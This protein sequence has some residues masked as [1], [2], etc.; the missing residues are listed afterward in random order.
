[1]S[2]SLSIHFWLTGRGRFQIQIWSSPCWT[3]CG[4]ASAWLWLWRCEIWR[5]RNAGWMKSRGHHQVVVVG[6]DDWW[7]LGKWFL[8]EL[9]QA[10]NLVLPPAIYKS[11]GII[12]SI[13][14]GYHCWWHVGGIP[15]KAQKL[16]QHDC[17]LGKNYLFQPTVQASSDHPTDHQ[18]I[19]PSPST[20]MRAW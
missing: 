16:S 17:F 13:V 12:N 8:W 4:V 10:I 20:T 6:V 3:T 1:M 14:L 2:S 19:F 15:A 9:A 7:P 18:L 5:L 11:N